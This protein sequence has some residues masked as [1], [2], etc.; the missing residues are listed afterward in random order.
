MQPL[1]KGAY[2]ML[3]HQYKIPERTSKAALPSEPADL[4][5]PTDVQHGCTCAL[6]IVD[7]LS[8]Q[9][10]VNNTWAD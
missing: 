6:Q 1:R 5:T 2:S 3:V 4:K 8:S 7:G 10:T 9:H